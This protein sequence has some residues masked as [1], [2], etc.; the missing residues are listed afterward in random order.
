QERLDRLTDAYIDR[1]IDK[2]AFEARKATILMNQHSLQEK[3]AQ[4]PGAVFQRLTKFLELAGDAYLLYKAS[5]PTEKRDLIKIVTSNRT[6]SGKNVAVALKTPFSDVANRY[7][8]S[9][10]SPKENRTPI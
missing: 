10:S 7:L 5:L 3:I 1:L 9:N 8:S 6:V 2:E 4:P